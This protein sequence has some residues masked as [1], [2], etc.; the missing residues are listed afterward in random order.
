MLVKHHKTNS[1]SLEYP[2]YDTND[3]SV[4]FYTR[5]H[6]R[7]SRPHSS[8]RYGCFGRNSPEPIGTPRALFGNTTIL[9]PSWAVSIHILLATV[10]YSPANSIELS[11]SGLER[12]ILMLRQGRHRGY[13]HRYPHRR[14]YSRLP[15]VHGL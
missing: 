5:N 13:C 7:L 6:I 4:D 10:S 15:I 14:R 3:E 8:C 12:E 1:W 9:V 2:R 11:Q